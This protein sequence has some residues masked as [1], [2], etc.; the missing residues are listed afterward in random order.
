MYLFRAQMHLNEL[1]LFEGL[2][3]PKHGEPAYPADAYGHGWEEKG[4]TV[5]N[6][7]KST[8]N[9]SAVL[10]RLFLLFVAIVYISKSDVNGFYLYMC[11]KMENYYMNT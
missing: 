4:D 2:D 1:V 10:G 5:R 9:S 7:I 6:M 11:W 8:I 3:I